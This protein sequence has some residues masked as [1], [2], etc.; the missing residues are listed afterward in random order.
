MGKSMSGPD[1]TDVEM[2]CRAIGS[3]HTGK[4][5]L[6]FLPQGIGATGGWSTAATILFDVLPGSA[7]PEVVTAIKGW[8]CVSHSTMAGH[9]FALLN[10]LDFKIGQ[11]YKNEKLWE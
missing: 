6:T 5:G 2:M 9:C 8:P 10:E 1:W 7:I 4:V 3:L 11:T